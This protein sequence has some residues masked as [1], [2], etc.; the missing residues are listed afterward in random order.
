MKAL[1]KKY[2]EIIVYIIVGVMTTIFCW[3]LCFI[4]KRWIFDVSKPFQNFVNNTLNWICGVSFAYPLNRRWVFKSKNKNILVEFLKFAA[5]RV[6]TWGVD[7][8]VMWLFVNVTDF[9][10]PISKLCSWVGY[11]TDAEGLE[12]LNYWFVKIF[13][14]SVLVMIFNYVFSKLIVFKK[15]KEKT[16]TKEDAEND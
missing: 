8:V 10:K 3:T 5:S 6:T 14:S 12:N 9:I 1:I 11:E 7:V 13:I 4:A 2:R 15:E 16:S